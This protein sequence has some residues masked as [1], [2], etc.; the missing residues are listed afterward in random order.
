[1]KLQK[2][3]LG[4]PLQDIMYFQLSI[5][6]IVLPQ[7][8]DLVDMGI[9]SYLVSSALVGVV[10]QRL[11][12]KLCPKCKKPYEASDID[13]KILGLNSDDDLILY[14]PQGCSSCNN[15]YRARTA[16][17]E[18]MPITEEIRYLINNGANIDDLRKKAIEEGMTTLLESASK[19]AI[20]GITS[21]EEVVRVG[22]TLD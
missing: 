15:G 9:E 20:E 17:Y 16:V 2:L 7:W 4:Q 18:I 21:F 8:Q 22:F 1:M 11:V 6:T 5:Q 13:K 12:K 10:S 19:L 14:M 3:P